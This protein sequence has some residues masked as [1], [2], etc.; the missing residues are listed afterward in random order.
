MRSAVRTITGRPIG[1]DE[2]G[3]PLPERIYRSMA[4]SYAPGDVEAT[5]DYLLS[6]H[7][8]DES[9]WFGAEYEAIP[10]EVDGKARTL[11]T[12]RHSEGCVRDILRGSLDISEYVADLSRILHL[13]EMDQEKLKAMLAH[14]EDK[15]GAG[16]TK[17]VV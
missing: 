12:N 1:P 6:D 3:L 5:I 14:I 9:L 8:I 11:Y 7:P 10:Y 17:R 16:L 13:E 2:L 4:G 15:L